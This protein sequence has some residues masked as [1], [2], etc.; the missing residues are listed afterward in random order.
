MP[1]NLTPQYK[2]AE[3]QWRQAKSL[4]EKR[5]ALE[6]MLATIP[7]HKGTEKLQADIKKRLARLRQEEESHLKRHGFSFRVEPEGAA[8]VVLLGPPNSGKS[9]LLA[10]L[11]RAEPAI[12][13]FPFTTTRPQ[14]GM[15]PFEDVKIQ[16]VD[17]PPI[18]K[19]H[20]DPWLPNLVRAA[21]AAALFIDPT[22]PEVPED[23]EVVRQR[24]AEMRI[25]LVGS[26][27][28]DA[29]CGDTPL[30]TVMV[31]TKI[32]KAREEDIQ[33]LVEL[34]GEVF[35][36]VKVSAVTHTG[37][38]LLKVALWR[39]LGLL[40]VYTKPPGKPVDRS[41]PFVLPQGS[42]VLDLAYRVHREVAEN[43]AFARV[44]GGK[45]EG[46]K[47]SRDFALRDRDVVEIHV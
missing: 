15:M 25:P 21:D 43:L 22:S 33:V 4:E 18:T 46:Q 30:P 27:P 24:L 11:T 6:T 13:E 20:L 29:D 2:A 8:Q 34:Y 39:S 44:W 17:L 38:E 45:L 23:A 3:V 14:P 9:S 12:G 37:L 1:A 42:T 16:L 5:Q 7:K 47:V 26:L 32:D 19:S 36:V 35:P 41:A 40:R 28:E 31:V 10:A